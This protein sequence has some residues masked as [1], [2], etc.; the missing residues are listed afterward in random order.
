MDIAD[1]KLKAYLEELYKQTDGD[2]EVQ[3]SMHDLGAAIGLDKAEAG[4][5]A[6]QLIVQGQAELRTLAGGISI[7]PEGLEILGI[8]VPLPPSAKSELSLG[9]GPVTDD[10]DRR[11]VQLLTEQIKNEISGINLEYDLL[12]EIVLD[13]KTI[14]VQLLSPRPK[15]AVLRELFRS[16]QDALEKGNMEKIAA[17][18]KA[19]MS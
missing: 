11:T 9:V 5:L 4:S 16:L 12:E 10:T 19:I 7:T 17:Q 14:E 2:C 1:L 13:L 3:V 8:S 18:L 6:E 15:I